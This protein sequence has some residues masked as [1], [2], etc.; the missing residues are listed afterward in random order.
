M[1]CLMLMERILSDKINICNSV[2]N[3]LGT[4]PVDSIPKIVHYN[5]KANGVLMGVSHLQFLLSW[6]AGPQV[7]DSSNTLT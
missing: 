3:L 1:S 5:P 4:N 7:D 6:L 2:Q